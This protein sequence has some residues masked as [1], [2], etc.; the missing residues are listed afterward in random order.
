VRNRGLSL[1]SLRVELYV[2]HAFGA[3]VLSGL[4][5]CPMRLVGT[6]PPE[7]KPGEVARFRLAE[8]ELER[9]TLIKDR[10]GPCHSLRASYY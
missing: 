6:V 3:S 4:R 1:P 8:R 7:L 2:R 10:G 9:A 5:G